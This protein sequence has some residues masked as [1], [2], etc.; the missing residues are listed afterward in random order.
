MAVEEREGEGGVRTASETPMLMATAVAISE[1]KVVLLSR[2]A[3]SN[4]GYSNSHLQ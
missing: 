4:G 2:V 1:L 3:I